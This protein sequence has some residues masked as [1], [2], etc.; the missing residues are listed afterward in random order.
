MRH[1]TFVVWTISSMILLAACSDGGGTTGPAPASTPMIT[2]TTE[3]V[4]TAMPPPS[5]VELEASADSVP[6]ATVAA[7]PPS[8]LTAQIADVESASY[9][10]AEHVADVVAPTVLSV[11]A[12]GIE[13]A[14]ITSVGVYLDGRFEVPE[15]EMVG[16]Y[17]FGP[18]PGDEGATVLAAHLNFDGVDGVFRRLEDVNVDDEVFVAS[19]DGSLRSYR[20]TERRLI[21]KN[22][23]P[24][25]EIWARTGESR[26]VLI[27]CGGRYDASRRS[28]DQNVVVFAELV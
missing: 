17:R 4:S 26:L 12:I 7:L 13:N 14:V 19:A 3:P 24:P 5:I 23:L 20:V 22:Q 25:E 6:E 8:P 9:D 28:Y 15:A 2:P 27:T 1:Q 11:P 18:A 21:D 10:P 16:W